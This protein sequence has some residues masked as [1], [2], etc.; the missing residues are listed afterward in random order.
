MQQS[1]SGASA[2]SIDL[3][4]LAVKRCI[5]SLTRLSA[6]PRG[7]HIRST[8]QLSNDRVNGRSSHLQAQDAASN[9][10]QGRPAQQGYR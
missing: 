4:K 7:P 8:Q 5:P 2:E 3:W 1:G 10:G 6:S 9:R